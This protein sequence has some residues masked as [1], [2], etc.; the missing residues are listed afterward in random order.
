VATDHERADDSGAG[1]SQRAGGAVHRLAAREA[2]I[3]KQNPLARQAGDGEMA[4][5]D[6]ASAGADDAGEHA[7][8]RLREPYSAP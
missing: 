2:V 1:R 7:A 8:R 5:A 6:V 3:Y 4:R